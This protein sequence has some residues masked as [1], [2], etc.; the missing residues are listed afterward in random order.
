MP[1]DVSCL[2]WQLRYLWKRRRSICVDVTG[3]EP[4]FIATCGAKYVNSRFTR[5]RAVA[6]TTGVPNKYDVVYR[7]FDALTGQCDRIVVF[8]IY[9][10]VLHLLLLHVELTADLPIAV[11]IT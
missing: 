7:R 5:K 1:G 2:S 10:V 6:L 4:V 3:P 9:A 11:C 8:E